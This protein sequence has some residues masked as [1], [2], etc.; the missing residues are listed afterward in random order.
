MTM[1][2]RPFPWEA[3]IEVRE[4]MATGG[5]TGIPLPLKPG[6]S[7]IFSCNTVKVFF[8]LAN[9]TSAKYT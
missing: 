9:M 7:V 8:F 1:S 2:S 5:E 4:K 3:T 6:S